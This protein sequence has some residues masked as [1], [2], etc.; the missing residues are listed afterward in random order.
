MSKMKQILNSK[1]VW[2]IISKPVAEEKTVAK[3][4]KK[5]KRKVGK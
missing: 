2:M 5:V 3:K 1:H 4:P